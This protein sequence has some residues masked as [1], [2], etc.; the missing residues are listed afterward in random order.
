MIQ[1]NGH[2]LQQAASRLLMIRP[3]A[4]AFNDQT[5]GSNSFQR[6]DTSAPNVQ[7]LALQEFNTAV[8]TLTKNGV[9]VLVKDET[10]TTKKPDAV[11]PNNWFSVHPEGI[12]LYPMAA[13]NRRL[14][15][16]KD[17]VI[18]LLHG[19]T[20]KQVIDLSQYET[21]GKFLEGTGSL[22]LDRT[23]RIAYA[24]LSPRTH[25]ALVHEWC[26]MLHYEPFIFS[27]ALPDTGSVYHT[28]VVMSLG[29]RVAVCCLGAI[30][31]SDERERLFEKLSQH[32]CVVDLTVDQMKCFAGNML[33]VRNAAGEH[34]WVLSQTA[35][36]VL[37]LS[38]LET[39]AL[40]GDLLPLSLDI[41]ETY[42]GG[43]ARCMLAEVGW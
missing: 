26:G 5:A 34:L 17:I 37:T 40:D 13:P 25:Q 35:Y 41:V 36:G 33:L 32:R 19:T 28:N 4:F 9:D 39:L 27:A 42:G 16:R 18:E 1:S 29:N 3:A 31:R 38:Q 43:S 14:E 23:H 7:A 21:T 10:A 8:E 30:T 22:V 2:P 12:V 24:C 15:R 6:N 11:F 20:G